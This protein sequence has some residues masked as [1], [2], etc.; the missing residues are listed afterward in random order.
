MEWHPITIESGNNK[1][2]NME[3]KRTS[4]GLSANPESLHRDFLSD[5]GHLQEIHDNHQTVMDTN[6]SNVEGN[7]DRVS[8][9][10]STEAMLDRFDG[11][12]AEGKI[13]LPLHGCELSGIELNTREINGD[14]IVK[15]N[16]TSIDGL[17]LEHRFDLP[18]GSSLAHA[19]WNNGELQL[20]LSK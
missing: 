8:G 19:I 6:F 11:K 14:S 17:E 10:L 9:V 16:V 20:T 5:L 2:A 7:F 13:M 1:S 18:K 15:L 4:E 3:N 12:I